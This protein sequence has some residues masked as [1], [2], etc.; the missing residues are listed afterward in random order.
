[1]LRTRDYDKWWK[2]QMARKE[3]QNGW[4][5]EKGYF[6]NPRRSEKYLSRGK[7]YARKSFGRH[8]NANFLK[9]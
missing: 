8:P 9:G 5:M 1:M 4:N 2:K 6:H 7:M 3:S